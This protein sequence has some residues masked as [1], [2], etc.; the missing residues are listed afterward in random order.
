MYK[1]NY[2]MNP[3]QNLFL[4]IGNSVVFATCSNFF[5]GISPAPTARNLG[6]DSDISL[7]PHINFIV[8]VVTT[9]HVNLNAFANI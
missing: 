5:I 4:T 6:V 2:K 1:N 8:R 3:D 7:I 9:T